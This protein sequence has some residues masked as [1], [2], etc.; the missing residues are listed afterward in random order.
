MVTI[1]SNILESLNKKHVQ[2][3]LDLFRIVS[4]V[5]VLVS[6]TGT[7]LLAIGYSF[8]YGYYFSGE[9]PGFYSIL[10]IVSNPIPFNFYSV[11][12]VSGLVTLSIVFLFSAIL[13][14]RKRKSHLIFGSILFF[15]V[16]HMCLSI[17]FVKGSDLIERVISF[18]IIWV[19]PIF[20]T[21]MIFWSFRAPLRMGS[22]LSGAL[23]GLY[24]L[25]VIA[26]IFELSDIYLQLLVPLCSFTLGILFTYF[27]REWVKYRVFRFV[28]VLPYSMLATAVCITFVEFLLDY[29][30]KTIVRNWLLFGIS[31]ALTFAISLKKWQQ[32]DLRTV[33]SSKSN[34]DNYLMHVAKIGK[35]TILA[36]LSILIVVLGTLTP[37]LSMIG[38]QY[39]REFTTDGVRELQLIHDFDNKIEIRGNIVSIKEGVYYISNENWKL[40]IINVDQIIVE[41]NSKR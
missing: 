36:T 22:S 32:N 21:I 18:S 10:D 8:L 12:I 35:S 4:V 33:D 39:I 40:D 27:S 6:L 34:F 2:Y 5:S 9:D 38:G 7:F 23:Y 20:I 37:Q 31:A 19:I 41:S 15:L 24:I 13:M 29:S 17:F 25:V 1:I 3:F 16:F 26:T 30:I 14:V 28:I 11:A